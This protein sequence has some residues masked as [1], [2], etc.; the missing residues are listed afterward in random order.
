MSWN[1]NSWE[2]NKVSTLDLGVF[3]ADANLKTLNISDAALDISEGGMI[4]TS[5]SVNAEGLTKI[6]ATG[7]KDHNTGVAVQTEGLRMTIDDAMDFVPGDDSTRLQVDLGD[8]DDEIVLNDAMTALTLNAGAGDDHIVGNDQDDVIHGDAGNDK[9]LGGAGN[10]ELYGDAGNDDISAGS[11]NDKLYGGDNDDILRF[12]ADLLEAADLIDGGNDWDKVVVEDG[13]TTNKVVGQDAFFYQWTNVE[14]LDLQT[15]GAD[16]IHL[17][18]IA[19]DSGL[20]RVTLSEGNDRLTLDEGFAAPELEV[21]LGNGNQRVINN[22]TTSGP[23]DLTVV[24]T[25][26]QLGAFDTLKGGMGAND[27][28]KIISTVAGTTAYLKRVTGFENVEITEEVEDAAINHTSSKIVTRNNTIAADETLTVTDTNLDKHDTVEFNGSA[29]HDGH[30]NIT[31]DATSTIT[32]GAMSDI[33]NT[34]DGDDDISGH[35]GDDIINAG[36]GTNTVHGGNGADTITTGSGDDT[37]DGG[38]NAGDLADVI[39][40]GDG[41]NTVNGNL[42]N[43]QITTGSGDD[44]ITGG[45]GDDT[46]ISGNAITGDNIEGNAGDDTITAGAGDDT[47]NGGAGK[48][49]LTGGAGADK[50]VYAGSDAS[51]SNGANRDKITDFDTTEEDKIAISNDLDGQSGSGVDYIGE[52]NGYGAAS[53]AIHAYEAANTNEGAT[54]LDTGSTVGSGTVYVDSDASG[55][56]DSDD[57]EIDL[58]GV[59][60]LEQSDFMTA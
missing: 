59:T 12:E 16:N 51:I 34:G 23:T 3:T 13:V 11:G 43:D 15:T 52:V 14:E 9:I 37:I 44:T 49:T 39:N 8:N 36:D 60:D 42:G 53:S 54:V 31:L 5:E 45:K 4:V 41:T 30:F 55:N 1:V 47:I 27:T 32:T 25:D 57:L 21:I 18:V 28:V 40:A 17:G 22:V 19:S 7:M 2:Y 56:L 6:D 46:I 58:I 29:E 20:Q 33:I 10:D 48:D 26:A 24:A 38:T 35:G 50:F